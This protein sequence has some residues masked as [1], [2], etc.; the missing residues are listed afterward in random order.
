MLNRTQLLLPLV[1]AVISGIP[2]PMSAQPQ[3]TDPPEAP[4]PAA[5]ETENSALPQAIN[6]QRSPESEVYLAPHPDIK[7]DPEHNIVWAATF[8]QAWQSAAPL[9]GGKLELADGP[10]WAEGMDSPRVIDL[11]PQEGIVAFGGM[12]TQENILKLTEELYEAFP[13]VDMPFEPPALVDDQGLLL[14]GYLRKNLIWEESF[15]TGPE[16]QLSFP[17]AGGGGPTPVKAFGFPK[18][19]GQNFTRQVHVLGYRSPEMFAIRVQLHNSYEYAIFA[20]GR[21]GP[22][23]TDSVKH[24]R[25]LQT[26][27][28]GL[29]DGTI[30][31]RLKLWNPPPLFLSPAD[32]LVLPEIDLLSVFSIPSLSGKSLAGQSADSSTTLQ[33]AQQGV[34]LET[35]YRGYFDASQSRVADAQAPTGIE[36]LDMEF[37]G[38]FSLSIWQQGAVFPYL[39]IQ[40]ATA[41]LLAPAE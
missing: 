2:L 29:E 34:R 11:L 17:A 40:I 15:Q 18:G 14:A 39:Y 33:E 27:R 7:L 38:P 30:S 8:Q 10:G 22:T 31:R 26:Y 41:D 12:A 25:L 19:A 20:R 16:L 23:I 1:I 24:L 35:G 21:F 28:K 4:G 9:K 37:S 5:A 3:E 32:R 36:P 13:V 6:T